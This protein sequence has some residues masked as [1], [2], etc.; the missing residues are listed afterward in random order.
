MKLS[1]DI[2]M[3]CVDQVIHHVLS[4]CYNPIK[5]CPEPGRSGLTAFFIVFFFGSLIRS[6]HFP[7][8]CAHV[9]ILM[10]ELKR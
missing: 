9:L 6:I 7:K 5:M 2:K 10:E 1:K 3:F 8:S 4:I